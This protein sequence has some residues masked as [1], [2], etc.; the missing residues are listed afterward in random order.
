ML[1]RHDHTARPGD[2]AGEVG[3]SRTWAG[4]LERARA[5]RIHR[6]RRTLRDRCR[7]R[8]GA[9]DW[10]L[11]C[12]LGAVSNG[13]THPGDNGP[14]R[15]AEPVAS[16]AER[17]HS[18]VDPETGRAYFR[19]PSG[20][21]ARA[22]EVSAQRG[23]RGSRACPRGRICDVMAAS[24]LAPAFEMPAGLPSKVL[25]FPSGVA[26]KPNLVA[27]NILSR[28]SVSTLETSSSFLPLP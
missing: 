20:G 15:R 11:A 21:L 7:A 23:R 12:S 28:F 1:H 13:I 10:I 8:P 22:L 25:S 2:Q 17:A 16:A 9:N 5:T 18:G 4:T 24:G 19:F 14:G 6:R 26:R 3:S 27:M